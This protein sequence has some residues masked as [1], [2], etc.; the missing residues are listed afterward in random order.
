MFCCL[1]I[2]VE[3]RVSEKVYGNTCDVVQKLKIV[4]WNG[5]PNTPLVSTLCQHSKFDTLP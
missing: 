2:C 1:K 3:I 4:V 5:V